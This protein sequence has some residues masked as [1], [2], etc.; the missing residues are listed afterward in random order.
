MFKNKFNAKCTY[1]PDQSGNYRKTL[2]ENND[3]IERLDW[4]P[5]DKLLNY[6][7]NLEKL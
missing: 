2:R 4:Q 7:N 3:A 6:I 5:Q 1:I